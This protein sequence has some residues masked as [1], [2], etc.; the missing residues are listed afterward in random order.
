MTIDGGKFTLGTL[1]NQYFA[2]SRGSRIAYI[3][4]TLWSDAVQSGL[5]KLAKN[6][7]RLYCDSYYSHAELKR[8]GQYRHMTAVHAAEL[9]TRAKV[10]QLILMHFAPRYASK[11]EALV[12]EARAHFPRVSADLRFAGLPPA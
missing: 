6:A 1:G 8:A 10:D 7:S 9:A 5:V 4:D 2:S 3:T 11:F 12:E